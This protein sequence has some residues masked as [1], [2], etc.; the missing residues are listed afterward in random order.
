MNNSLSPST[1]T[2]PIPAHWAAEL[3]ACDQR[4]QG[5]DAADAGAIDHTLQQWRQR[6]QRPAYPQEESFDIVDANGSPLGLVAPRWFC[7]L[8][9]LRHRV[10]HIYL[11]TP[12]HLL[13]LQKR[14]H[15]K[16]EWPGLFDTTVGG[17]IKA[18]QDW[19]RG[20][21]SEIEEEIGLPAA[22]IDDWLGTELSRVGAPFLRYDVIDAALPVR[23]RQVNQLFAAGISPW[24]LAS[25]RFADGEVE[26]VFLCEPAEARRMVEDNDRIAPGL[27]STFAYWWQ[28]H[29]RQNA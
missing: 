1:P 4:W 6:L 11:T 25:L 17:H 27:R 22:G 26:G 14:A 29:Q 2:L 15:T 8:T 7:H 5:G 19:M 16:P 28:W 13:I 18:G 21:L 23:N 3:A 24:G 12:Q 20:L 10:I 9:G